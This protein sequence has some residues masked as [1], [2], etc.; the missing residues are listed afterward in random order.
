MVGYCSQMR[1]EKLKNSAVSSSFA[2]IE[3]VV[4]EML[5]A[6][7]RPGKVVVY[8]GGSGQSPE[9]EKGRK[10]GSA[11][12]GRR[13]VDEAR[14]ARFINSYPVHSKCCHFEDTLATPRGTPLQREV[15]ASA[16]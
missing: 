8:V 11:T 14:F 2:C 15:K 6:I 3:L 4:I 1:I 12:T 10:V 5:E 16:P 7:R 13:P 9:Q